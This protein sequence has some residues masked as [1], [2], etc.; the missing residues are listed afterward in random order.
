MEMPA[1]LQGGMGAG[2]RHGVVG[3]GLPPSLLDNL[4]GR[5]SGKAYAPGD[6]ISL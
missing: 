6:A 5:T 4:V 3:G 1:D 2:F